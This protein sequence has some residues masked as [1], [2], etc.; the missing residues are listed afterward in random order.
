M[1]QEIVNPGVKHFLREPLVLAVGNPIKKFGLANSGFVDLGGGVFWKKTRDAS[2]CYAGTPIGQVLGQKVG[3]QHQVAVEKQEVRCGRRAHTLVATAGELEP[4]VL[5]GR[6]VYR[7]VDAIS[8]FGYD[9]FGIVLAA[10]VGDNDFKATGD[11]L[12]QL[13]GEQ[14]VA[15]M[16]RPLVSRDENRGG[17][18]GAAA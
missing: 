8:E 4:F 9:F 14:R 18:L 16:D 17:Q 3:R 13:N 2:H 15:K 6:E 12:L 5:V 11:A 10:V 1:T 7:K